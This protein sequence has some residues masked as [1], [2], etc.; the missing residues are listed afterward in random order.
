MKGR[1]QL[2]I[3][4]AV[5]GPPGLL[6]LAAE[7]AHLVHMLLRKFCEDLVQRKQLHAFPHLKEL[8]DVRQ[9]HILDKKAHI[10]DLPQHSLLLQ[11]EKS[12]PHGRVADPQLQ[13][14]LPGAEIA[15][16][17][18]GGDALL[19]CLIGHAAEQLSGHGVPPSPAAW[20]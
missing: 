8:K 16:A 6:L 12:L 19:D 11:A 7:T 20:P 15:S 2:G 3:A 18:H 1:V 14:A 5:P 9:V 13:G 4:I 17:G 10:G